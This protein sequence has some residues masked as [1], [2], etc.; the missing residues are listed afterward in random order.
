LGVPGVEGLAKMAQNSDSFGSR[1][2]AREVYAEVLFTGDLLESVLSRKWADG[3]L[4]VGTE[5]IS[6]ILENYIFKFLGVETHL[7]IAYNF[8]NANFYNFCFVK[9]SIDFI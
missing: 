8:F 9:L 5:V 6:F 4:G 7:P 3:K 1:V 2:L